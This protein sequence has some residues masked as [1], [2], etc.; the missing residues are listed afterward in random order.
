MVNQVELHPRLQLP[1]LIEFCS[2]QGILLTAWRPIM[3]GEVHEI[4]VL[5]AI[6]D[7]RW[8]LQRGIIAIP[9]S[10]DMQ[11]IQE[12]AQIF[13]FELDRDEVEQI[14][15]LDQN[16]RFGPDPDTYDFDF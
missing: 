9:K 4:P 14:N 8:L 11:R 1:E 12:N 6:A 3:K 2:D 13:D 15:S 10:Q 7:L 5:K 16:Q